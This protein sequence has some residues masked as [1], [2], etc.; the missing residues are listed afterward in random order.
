[1]YMHYYDKK[2]LVHD[3]TLKDIHGINIE[4]SG[5]NK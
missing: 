1:M 3:C 2:I 5:P 4:Y